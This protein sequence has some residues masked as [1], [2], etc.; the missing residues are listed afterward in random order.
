MKFL[1]K[2]NIVSISTIMLALI[3]LFVS[4]SDNVIT[5]SHN[6]YTVTPILNTSIQDNNGYY[7][8]FLSN[9]GY[10]PALVD[11]CVIFY[12]GKRMNAAK[13]VWEEIFSLEYSEEPIDF[14]I[15]NKYIDIGRVV[16]VGE[17]ILIWGA[18]IDELKGDYKKLESSLSNISMKIYYHSIYYQKFSTE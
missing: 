3:A 5:R 12:K 1:N 17:D 7:G 4:I 13:K 9:Q 6:K 15:K 14:S 2:D 16:R 8:L 11:S 10:G 18:S